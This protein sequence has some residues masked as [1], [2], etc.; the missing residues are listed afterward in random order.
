MKITELYELFIHHPHITTDSRNCPKGSIFFALKGERFDGNTYAAAALAAGCAY[1][2]IDNPEYE[3]GERTVLVDDTLKALQ[4]LA[5]RHRK[6]VGCPVIAITGTNG[7]TTTKELVAT[8]LSTHFNT[9][10]TTGNL[11]NQIGVP[12]TLLR[13]THDHEMAV[14]EMGASHPGDIKELVEI[15]HPNFG[16]ITNVGRAHLEGFGSF[17]GVVQTKAELYDYLRRVKGKIFINQDNPYLMEMAKGIEQIT[18]GT[19]D[20]AFA[21]GQV[22]SCDPMLTL[23]WRQ[24][25]K[26][27][28]V[29]THLIG[30]YNLENVLAAVAIGRYFKIPAERISRAISNYE[31]TN[32]RSQLM[33]T[34]HNTLIIDAYNANPSSMQVAL[35]NFAAMPGSPK[36]VILG[37]MRELGKTSAQLH[38]EVLA[39]IEKHHFDRVYLCGEEFCKLPSGF[40][41]FISTDEL[42]EELKQH[43]LHNY[44]VLIKGSHGMALERTLDTL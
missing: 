5:T 17:E 7:K 34:A 36:A 20:S 44:Q 3:Q 1:A 38:A 18:Y 42:I 39:L 21:R 11:N 15:A 37:D 32:N 23:E 24:Q 14:I 40:T 28:R 2:V 41:K 4:Q 6:A 22:I 26:P 12:L 43:P 9:L 31:P 25:G 8:V 35:D 27:H 10:Y 13:L 29:E 16:L 30:A 19:D 33:Q